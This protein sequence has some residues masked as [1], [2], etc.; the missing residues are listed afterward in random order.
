MFQPSNSINR[1]P[2]ASYLCPSFALQPPTPL[3]LK[4][5]I[6]CFVKLYYNNTPEFLIPLPIGWRITEYQDRRNHGICFLLRLRQ[7]SS[8]RSK[9]LLSQTSC[10]SSLM[11]L[12]KS[13]SWNMILSTKAGEA[14]LIVCS[15]STETCGFP[16]VRCRRANRIKTASLASWCNHQWPLEVVT[17]PHTIQ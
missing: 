5:L 1:F 3:L 13:R 10:S 12:S 6:I 14:G 9:P 7:L 2:S 17:M 15:F 4:C 8:L 11:L 16:R